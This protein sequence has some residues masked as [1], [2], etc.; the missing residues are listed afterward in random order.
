[1]IERTSLKRSGVGIGPGH[2][3]EA[4]IGVAKR[5]FDFCY[6]LNGLMHYS[7][8]CIGRDNRPVR[9][10][11]S[12]CFI[13][14]FEWDNKRA[15]RQ[16]FSHWSATLPMWSRMGPE[17]SRGIKPIV[18]TRYVGIY[19]A[20]RRRG[21]VHNTLCPIIIRVTPSRTSAKTNSSAIP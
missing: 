4:G 17:I 3:E 20:M 12:A 9:G 7:F 5:D 14:L 6:A 13:F 1:M 16:N 19:K 10:S 2:G 15:V 11:L 8:A 21:A 18:R